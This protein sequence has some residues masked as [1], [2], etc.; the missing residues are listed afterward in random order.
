MS[1]PPPRAKK[2][3]EGSRGGGS[4]FAS[5]YR[6]LSFNVLHLLA[7][8]LDRRLYSEPGARQLDIG[9]FRAQRIG[10]AIELLAEKVE[11]TPDRRALA[12]QILRR[13]EMRRQTVELLADVSAGDKQGRLLR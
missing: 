2:A 1:C 8:L 4:R 7:Q 10:F 9:G 3:R 6:V 11:A 12:Q 13:R 5:P